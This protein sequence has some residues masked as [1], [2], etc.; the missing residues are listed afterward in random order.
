MKKFTLIFISALSVTLIYSQSF[1]L[2][3][4]GLPLLPNAEI[5]LTSHPDSGMMVLDTLDVKNI[6]DVTAEVFCART[7]VENIEGTVNSFCWGVCYPPFIDTSS[8]A[9]TILPQA[10][11]FEFV[12]DHDPGGFV[13]VVKVKYTFYDSH[14]SGNQ[15]TVFVNYDATSSGGIG[16]LLPGYK[17]SEAYPNPAN[18]HTSIDYD[19]NGY[20]NSRIVIY[21]LLGSAVEQLDVSG[22]AGTAKFNTS[23][24][25]EG[26]YFYS[27]VI[28]NEVVRTQKL[29]IRH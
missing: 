21:N 24:Y 16:D 9:V 11:S 1:E 7:I 19:F 22:K 20:R 26:I 13:G 28:N 8:V 2:Y 4:Q 14:N 25:N 15:I 12:G 18:H 17:M 5:T 27:L 23:M 10:T 3:F 6:S 29:I